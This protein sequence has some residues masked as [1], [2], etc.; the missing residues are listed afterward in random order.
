MHNRTL[1]QLNCFICA[2][3]VALLLFVPFVYSE[4]QDSGGISCKISVTCG[5]TTKECDASIDSSECGDSEVA[6]CYKIRSQNIRCY[7]EAWCGRTRKLV[8]KYC[9]DGPP[10]P[11]E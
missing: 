8:E 9:D 11:P 4:D 2:A 10:S 7:A 1:I 5:S 6:S 3:N